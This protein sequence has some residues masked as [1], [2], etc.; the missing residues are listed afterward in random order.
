MLN[1][2]KRWCTWFMKSRNIVKNFCLLGA[3][4]TTIYLKIYL[5]ICSSILEFLYFFDLWI[6]KNN[7]YEILKPGILTIYLCESDKSCIWHVNGHISLISSHPC[8][9]TDKYYTTI[10]RSHSVHLHEH[11]P[12]CML[13]S[14]LAQAEDIPGVDVTRDRVPGVHKDAWSGA[15][16]WHS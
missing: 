11:L 12:P 5:K 6:E 14:I 1:S 15:V 13:L 8:Q 4:K 2:W 16:W 7:V 10:F 3:N 9:M